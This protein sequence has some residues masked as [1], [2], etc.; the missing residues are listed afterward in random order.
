MWCN[1]ATPTIG[2]HAPL[3]NLLE[4]SVRGGAARTFVEAPPEEDADYENAD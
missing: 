1:A 3:N 2:R 4:V